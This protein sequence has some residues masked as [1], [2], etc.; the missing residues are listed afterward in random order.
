M[1]R[2]LAFLGL[3]VAEI[4]GACGVF[5]L[6]SYAH[7]AIATTGFGPWLS[8]FFDDEALKLFEPGLGFWVSG[9]E[10]TLELIALLMFSVVIGLVVGGI[11]WFISK[12]WKWAERITDK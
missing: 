9:H 6:L 3:A 1:K 7:Q 10:A 4:G 5:A 12:N 2:I 8:V 11:Y